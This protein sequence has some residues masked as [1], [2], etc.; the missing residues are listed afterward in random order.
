MSC[1]CI[2]GALGIL[3]Y[4]MLVGYTPFGTGDGD[5]TQLFRNIAMVRTGANAV[6]FP[7]HLLENCPHACDLVRRLLQGDPAKRIG[8]GINGDQDVRQHPWFS[9]IEWDKMYSMA[10]EPP[11][12]PPLKGKY[13]IS[14]FEGEIGNRAKDKPFDGNGDE[15]FLGF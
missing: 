2:A 11:Y 5:T 12:L 4:E 1:I 3:I 10:L 13:D 9:K 7:F 15:F 14:L 6:D 8:V